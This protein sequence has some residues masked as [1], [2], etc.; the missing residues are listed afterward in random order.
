MTATVFYQYTETGVRLRID[1]ETA[2]I[3]LG[4]HPDHP[5][6][7]RVTEL[8]VTYKATEIRDGAA[9]ETAC[10]VTNITYLLA[11]TETPVAYVHPDYCDQ[12]QEWPG[13]V[14]DLVAANRPADA[15]KTAYDRAVDADGL[16]DLDGMR[17]DHLAPCRVPDSPDCTCPAA[18]V[19][20]SLDDLRA[21]LRG[22]LFG[23]GRGL[24]QR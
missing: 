13:W 21:A 16:V 5:N 8:A 4:D 19:P 17:R 18:E 7:I 20:A 6:R 9:V 3:D 1:D 14:R 10:E 2:T 22:H 12:P 11:S 24:D 23:G 15:S